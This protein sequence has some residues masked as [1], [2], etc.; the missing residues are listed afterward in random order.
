MPAAPPSPAVSRPTAG[1]AAPTVSRAL[2]GLLL[3]VALLV[4][5][6][7]CSVGGDGAAPTSTPEEAGPTLADGPLPEGWTDVHGPGGLMYSVP[8]SWKP[9]GGDA[10]GAPPEDDSQDWGS[11]YVTTA[12]SVADL[13]Y[14]PIG[15]GMSFRAL[16]GLTQPVA[17]HARD[18]AASA[19]RS[20]ADS[21][22]SRFTQNGADVPRVDPVKI[23]VSGAPAWHVSLRGTVHDPRNRCT[24]P[25]IRID[26]VAVRTTTPDGA[27]ASQLF[28]LMAD[29]AEPGVQP[30][31]VVDRV[32]ASLRFDNSI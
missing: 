9:L 25:T 10:P 28:V 32:V 17:G 2:A 4:A 27:E 1:P 11:G 31:E 6:A 20:L 3:P 26:A 15:G 22:D 7:G 16:A 13:G 24:P 30:T 14:C 18:Q 21:L 12:N 23:G 19:S 5:L 29:E 8:P